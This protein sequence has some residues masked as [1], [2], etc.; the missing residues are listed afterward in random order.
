MKS[1]LTVVGLGGSLA[2]LSTSLAALRIA[3]EGAAEAG[4][5]TELLDIREL[6]LPMYDP[7]DGNPPTSVVKLCDAVYRADG[8][9]WS[10]PMYNGTISG[11]FKNALDWLKLLGDRKPA[12]LTD[13]VVGLIST[14]G[15]VQGLQAVN[16]MEF[17]VRAL[18]GWA[19]PLVMPIAQSWKVFDQQ[20]ASI[21][22]QVTEQ[23]HALGREVARASCQFALA[24]PTK[25]DAQKAEA[26]TLPVDEEEAK[27]A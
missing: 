13:K 15:G 24:P 6:A 9:L 19:V 8:L 26:E 25:A 18:R 1:Q 2:K 23:L 17:V 7:E 12:Y 5:Q 11:S 10:S 3:L 21:D 20:G 27:S 14:A 4:A 16:T 22:K